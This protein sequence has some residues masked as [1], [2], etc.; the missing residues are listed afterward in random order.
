VNIVRLK[1]KISDYQAWLDEA[2]ANCADADF[3]WYRY[4]SLNNFIH[5]DNLLTGQNRDIGALA[6]GQRIVDIGAADGDTA[7]ALAREGFQVEIVDHGATNMN[8]LRGARLLNEHLKLNV[9][10][11]D[12]D[13]DSQFELPQQTYGLAIFLGIL[14]HLKNPY[15]VLENLAKRAKHAIVSTRIARYMPQKDS[16]HLVQ[17]TP[18]AYLLDAGEANGDATNYWIFSDAGLKRLFQR[19]GWDVLDYMTVGDTE[20]SNPIDNANDERAFALLRSRNF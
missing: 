14:Y 20:N 10:I 11:R 5:L 13:L 19:T 6:G 9:A 18:L 15:L 12:T 2:R 16:G 7:F 8:G 3:P 4:G 17:S 1:E